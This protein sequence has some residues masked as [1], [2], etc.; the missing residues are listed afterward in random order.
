MPGD[1]VQ[2]YDRGVSRRA[3]YG[4]QAYNQRVG[5]KDVKTADGG[6]G[7]LFKAWRP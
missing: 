3:G 1:G 4:V 6:R 7:P 5:V 2:A